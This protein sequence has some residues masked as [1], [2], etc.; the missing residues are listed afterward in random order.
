MPPVGLPLLHEEEVEGVV[1]SV[2]VDIRAR[3][4][5]V[6]ALFKAFAADPEVL[7]AAWLQA[8]AIY[9][10]PRS[11]AAADQIRNSAR[12]LVDFPPSRRVSEAVAPFAA[13]LPYMLLIVTSLQLTLSGELRLR[14]APEPNLPA[15]TVVLEP[16]FPDRAEHALFPEICAVYGTQHLPSIFRTLAAKGVLEQTWNAIGPFLASPDGTTAVARVN[17]EANIRAKAMPEVASFAAERARPIL[18]QFSRAL[19]RNLILAVTACDEHLDRSNSKAQS[20]GM[21][22]LSEGGARGR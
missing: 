8:R 15:A 16:E 12:V 14:P 22:G 9:D 5:F 10:D 13:E 3:M 1:A 17:R 19:P 4:P 11:T 2:F 7:V 20:S 18:D 21:V 6:P